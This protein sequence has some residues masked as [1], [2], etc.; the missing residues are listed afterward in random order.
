MKTVHRLFDKEGIQYATTDREEL[1]FKKL[2]YVEGK[3]SVKEYISMMKR[4]YGGFRW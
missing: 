3:D 4:E 2:K 1:E